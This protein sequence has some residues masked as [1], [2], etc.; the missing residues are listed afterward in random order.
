MNAEIAVSILAYISGSNK[1]D[2]YHFGLIIYFIAF[3]ISPESSKR[4]F[5]WFALYM[6]F[7]TFEKYAYAIN[8]E[9][10]PSD[11]NWGMAAK[12]L[13]LSSSVT[14]VEGAK[15]WYYPFKTKQWALMITMFIVY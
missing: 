14:D 6:V 1:V 4:N 8:D 15:Y 10:V 12:F 9:L 3:W 11:T 13:G 7:F 5:F 2:G